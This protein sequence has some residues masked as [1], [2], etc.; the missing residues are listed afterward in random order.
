MGYL[1]QRP[2]FVLFSIKIPT[3][4]TEIP[5]SAVWNR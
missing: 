2:Q 4:V 3:H 5:A 1:L